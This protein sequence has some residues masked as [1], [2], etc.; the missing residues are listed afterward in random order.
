MTKNWTRISSL[1]KF[2]FYDFKLYID[3][4]YIT[5]L[6]LPNSNTSIYKYSIFL[7]KIFNR[8]W[9]KKFK[10]ASNVLNISCKRFELCRL[11]IRLSAHARIPGIYDGAIQWGTSAQ[12]WG[13]RSWL[14]SIY[15]DQWKILSRIDNICFPYYNFW[16]TLH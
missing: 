5:F 6:V 1:S 13:N 2:L 3:E 10:I 12:C 8:K 14:S 15:R 9:K 4:F 7:R 11:Q 16:P